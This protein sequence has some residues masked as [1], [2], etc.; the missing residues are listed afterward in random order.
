M[1]PVLVVQHEEKCPPAWFG[2]WL[3]EAGAE[4]DVRRM[5][6]GD[7]LPETLKDHDALLILGGTMSANDDQPWYPPLQ[8]LIHEAVES[9]VPTLGICLGHQ[10]LAVTLGGRVERNPRGQAMGVTEVGWTSEAADDPLLGAVSDLR[11]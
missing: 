11:R 3:Q 4:V 7:S 2:R 1:K 10:I 6:G 9:A 5:D 8:G